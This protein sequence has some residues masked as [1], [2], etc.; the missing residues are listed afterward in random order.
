MKFTAAISAI[1]LVS[2][3]F[4]MYQTSYLQ[5]QLVMEQAR[6]QAVYPDQLCSHPGRFDG[7]GTVRS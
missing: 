1:I 6:Q 3:G 7:I 4:L 2:Y 5:Y